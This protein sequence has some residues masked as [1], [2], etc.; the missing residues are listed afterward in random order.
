MPPT[1]KAQTKTKTDTATPWANQGHQVET[2]KFN[3]HQ[4]W[5]NVFKRSLN[6]APCLG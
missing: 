3:Q 6:T 1:A 5:V 4:D 2:D